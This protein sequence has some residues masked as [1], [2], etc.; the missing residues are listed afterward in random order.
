M[1]AKK[2]LFAA[3]AIAV[4]GLV[5]F[6]ASPTYAASNTTN[7]I[8]RLVERFSLNRD[9]L[10]TVFDEHR[11]DLMT[12]HEQAMKDRLAQTVTDGKITQAQADLITAK[13]AEL[14]TFIESLKEKTMEERRDAMK[15]KMDELKR[16]AEDNDIPLQYLNLGMKGPHGKFGP[17]MGM[18]FRH[19]GK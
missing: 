14:K 8:D 3:S 12:E 6:H 10:Q 7:L 16:W 13:H 2:S 4:L 1:K 17:R 9:D 18:P 5:V 19:V 11:S 15:T